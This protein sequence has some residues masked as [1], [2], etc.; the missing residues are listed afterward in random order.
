M[1][2]AD[3]MPPLTLPLK[4]EFQKLEAE[5]RA[6]LN[7][8]AMF[9][10]PWDEYLRSYVV[11]MYDLY[12]DFY[13]QFSD[14][15][16]HWLIAS[17]H[18]ASIR[19]F[20]MLRDQFITD[21]ELFPVYRKKLMETVADYAKRK[22]VTPPQ[23]KLGNLLAKADYIA[24]G[25]DISST[26]PLLKM[27]MAMPTLPIFKLASPKPQ[28]MPGVIYA[29]QAAKRME[30]FIKNAGMKQADF[31]GHAQTT[32]RTLLRFRRS[33]KVRSA[34]LDG[35]AN[36]MRISREDLLSPAPIRLSE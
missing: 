36:A 26:T 17:A 7:S 13:S 10:A 14:L 27:A 2:N 16:E 33:G 32:E 21:E 1:F 29:P 11:A 8:T 23:P 20:I 34:I 5:L 28:R 24:A 6:D 3:Q 9:S 31:A 35:I 15:R 30:D 4:R 25:I 19:V 12:Y 18:N 22:H